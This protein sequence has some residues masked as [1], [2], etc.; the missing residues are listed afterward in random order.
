MNY[1]FIT[2]TSRGIGLS[3]A[4]LLLLEKNNFI[5]GISRNCSIDGQNYK[6]VTIDLGNQGEVL[7]FKFPKHDDAESIVLINNAGSIGEIKPVGNKNN[8]DIILSFNINIISPG[9]FIN[10]FIKTYQNYKCKKMIINISSGAGRHP[11]RSLGAYSAAKA[12]LDMFSRVVQAE[13]EKLDHDNQV[14]IFSVAPGIVNTK[15]Q[16]EIR[17]TKKEDFSDKDLYLMYKENN[18][19]ES[20]E[21]VAAKLID[22]IRNPESFPDAVFELA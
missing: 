10:N 18:L 9:I 16:E 20:P 1:Y 15:M 21:N 13:Q 22:I 17:K 5:T 14:R 19:L 2:G 6:H 7:R 4:E 11:V 8:D 12:A 3:L